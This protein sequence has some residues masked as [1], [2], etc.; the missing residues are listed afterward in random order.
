MR[1][2]G[3]SEAW[4]ENAAAVM[5]AG[6]AAVAGKLPL[7]PPRCLAL[8]S[9]ISENP[10]GNTGPLTLMFACLFMTVTC[11]LAPHCSLYSHARLRSLTPSLPHSRARGKMND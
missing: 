9:G 4:V 8:W 10:D 2:K 5:T 7:L 1:G 6:A 3:K 11:S